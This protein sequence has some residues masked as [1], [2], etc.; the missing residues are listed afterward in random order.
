[1]ENSQHLSQSQKIFLNILNFFSNPAPKEKNFPFENLIREKFRIT[2]APQPNEIVEREEKKD[3]LKKKREKRKILPP[4]KKFLPLFFLNEILFFLPRT[5]TQEM[6]SDPLPIASLGD[7]LEKA[8]EPQRKTTYQTKRNDSGP[9]EDEKF[10]NGPKRDEK[11]DPQLKNRT[12]RGKK[13]QKQKGRIN[14]TILVLVFF[15][16]MDTAHKKRAPHET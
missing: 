15:S 12:L 3:P 7:P 6:G 14:S 4:E 2:P 8:S 11:E 9:P 10:P 1:M 5:K 16:L 13:E